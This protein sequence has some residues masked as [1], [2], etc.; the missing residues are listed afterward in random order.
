VGFTTT[1]GGADFDYIGI[2][3]DFKEETSTD[4]RR[5]AWA[6]VKGKQGDPGKKGDNGRGIDHIETFYLL[7]A[8]GTAPERDA[9]DWRSTPPVPT[10]QTPWLWTYE[11]VVYSDG[12]NER[13]KVRLVTRLA[14][15]GAEAEPTRP[16]LLD[17]TDFHQDG[18]W[19]SGLNGTHTKTEKVKDVQPAVTGCGVLRTL[20]ERGAVGEEYAQFS[21]RIPV[22][23]STSS[24]EGRTPTHSSP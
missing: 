11:R 24:R 15:D 14:K 4:W 13:T 1:P 9:R 10:P 12:N 18:A 21:Q 2:Y 3:T 22:E 20:V 16:N 6:R 19:E 5:Y 8:D 7:T 23:A 17:G